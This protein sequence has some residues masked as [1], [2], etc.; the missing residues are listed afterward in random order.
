MHKEKIIYCTCISFCVH[1]SELIYQV[2]E[3]KTETKR[4]D[5]F[6]LESKELNRANHVLRLIIKYVD[7][8]FFAPCEMLRCQHCRNFK[9]ST[10]LFWLKRFHSRIP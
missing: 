1:R 2:S 10:S 3:S 5:E 9:R 6:D 7:A 8:I 4:R